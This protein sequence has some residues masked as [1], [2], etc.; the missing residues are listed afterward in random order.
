MGAPYF[1]WLASLT[2]VCLHYDCLQSVR[3]L[4]ALDVGAV[5][6]QR[7]ASLTL[8]SSTTW[9]PSTS[10]WPAAAW[11]ATATANLQGQHERKK[12]R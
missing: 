10:T 6:F 8:P 2:V 9:K 5:L 4:A 12:L 1:A 3:L 7:F 11:N